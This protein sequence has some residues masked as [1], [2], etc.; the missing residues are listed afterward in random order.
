MTS[1]NR[2][3]AAFWIIAVIALIWNLMGVMAYLGQAYM[4]DEA[5]ALLTEAEKALYD[6]VPIWVTA[7]FAIAVFGGVL[8]SIALLMRKQIAKLYF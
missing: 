3:K 5:K 2:P 6:N 8:A 4:T 1:T 7:A